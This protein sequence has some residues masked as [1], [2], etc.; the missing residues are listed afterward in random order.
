MSGNRFVKPAIRGYVLAQSRASRHVGK[1]SFN[2]WYR[3]KI[4]KFNYKCTYPKK[5]MALEWKVED[6]GEGSA[7][8]CINSTLAE[9]NN[10][11]YQVTIMR[12]SANKEW[13]GSWS[14]GQIGLESFV[15]IFVLILYTYLVVHLYLF[16][17]FNLIFSPRNKDLKVVLRC[18]VLRKSNLQG[19]SHSVAKSLPL[20]LSLP[21][22][23]DCSTYRIYQG[24]SPQ[25]WC[26]QKRTNI[27]PSHDIQIVM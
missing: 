19:G 17:I 18:V 27:R 21:F 22:T 12:F 26:Y 11:E 13:E 5:Y 3:R 15:L 6:G 8:R 16:E 9:S 14:E 2:A 1:T 20:F 10:S 24:P 23:A 4:V 7:K 25:Q